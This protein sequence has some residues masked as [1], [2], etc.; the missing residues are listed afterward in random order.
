MFTKQLYAQNDLQ[1][2]GAN[3]FIFVFAP[4]SVLY[5]TAC[6]QA[7]KVLPNRKKRR[8][9]G[10]FWRRAKRRQTETYSFCFK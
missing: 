6:L 10:V 7:I 4:T 9:A 1:G 5:T 3:K 8:K 2:H